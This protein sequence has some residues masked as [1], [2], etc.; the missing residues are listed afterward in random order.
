MVGEEREAEIT[1]ARELCE[2]QAWGE[3]HELLSRLDQAGPL[4]AHDTERLATSAYLVGRELDY[5]RFLERAH[6]LHLEHGDRQRAARSA[7]WSGLMLLLRGDTARSNGWLAR[8]HRLVEG[9]SCVEHGYLLLPVAERHLIAHEGG[10]ALVVATD[11]AAIGDRFSDADVTACALHLMGRALIQQGEVQQGLRLLDETMIAAS[12]GE[13]SPI[14]TGLIYCSVIDACQEVFALGRAHEWTVALTRWCDRQPEM[15]AF[16]RTCLVHR[17][18]VMQFRGAW[19]EA[20]TETRLAYERLSRSGQKAPAAAFYRQGELHRLKGEFEAAEAAYRRA[21]ESGA[22]PQPGFA[23]LRLAQGRTDAACAAIRRVA[24]AATDPLQR[25]QLL[26]AVVE[27]TLAAGAV[28]DARAAAAELDQIARRYVTDTLE[29]MAA[30]AL[31]AVELADGRA[32]AALPVLRRAFELWQRSDAPY[33]AARTRVLIARACFDL[34]DAESGEVEL[35]TARAVFDRLGAAPDLAQ[36][37]S[38]RA[39]TTGTPSHRLTSREGEVLHLIA[40]G[41]TN[42]AI[43]ADLSI[44]ERTVDRHVSNI[45]TKLGVPSRAAAIAFAYDHRLL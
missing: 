5:F 33:D 34:G 22:E 24:G 20:M 25:A 37:T 19:A 18:H 6:H 30:Q 11:A 32:R 13:L 29:A 16:T 27:I 8:A 21:S 38:V 40:A 35:E 14:M 36:L 3:A 41:K 45:L 1:R 44:S 15:V 17:A 28:Q 7:A 23:L 26:P 42:K 43:A 10:E 39:R 2:R 31:G 9:H 12:G 4:A